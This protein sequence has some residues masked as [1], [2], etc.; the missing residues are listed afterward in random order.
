MNDEASD[1]DFSLEGGID[2]GRFSDAVRGA[3]AQLRQGTIVE[4]PPFVYAASQHHPLFSASVAWAESDRAA[5]GAVNVLNAARRAP[6]GIIVTQTC[7][8]VEEGSRPKRP[9]VLIAPVYT[10]TCDAGT[11][12]L[13]EQARGYDYL[14]P[15]TGLEADLKRFWVA[16]LR[17]L[18]PV[19]KGWLV[20]VATSAGFGDEVGYDRLGRQLSSLFARPAYATPLIT[21]ILRPLNELLREISERWAD[22]P[23]VD[24]GLALG[25]SRVDPTN[26]QVV[27][28]LDGPMDEELHELIIA[29][30][31]HIVEAS[32]SGLHVLLPRTVSVDDLTVREYRTLDII[33]LARFSPGG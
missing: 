9:W 25:R 22:D 1:P 15:I 31:Q 29:W 23:I 2:A 5:T 4:S 12:K 32:P 18:M 10:L 17:L 8:L 26:A 16:D 14:C 27:F 30:G 6:R 20:G 3:T 19:E 7:D 33:D 21:H 13:I 11:R 24:V 28:V